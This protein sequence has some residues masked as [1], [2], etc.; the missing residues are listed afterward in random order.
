MLFVGLSGKALSASCLF[1]SF[2]WF[3]GLFLRSWQAMAKITQEQSRFAAFVMRVGL[4]QSISEVANV[5]ARVEPEGD[6][7]WPAFHFIEDFSE[8]G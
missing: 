1:A 7:A 3:L 2:F 4:A 5:G 8:R 6:G